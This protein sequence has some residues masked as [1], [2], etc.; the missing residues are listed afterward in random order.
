MWFAALGD[1]RQSPWFVSFARR[2]LEGSP[3]VLRLLAA[4]PFGGRPPRYLRAELFDYRFTDV[5]TRRRTGAWWSRRELGT[6]LPAVSLDD[7][8]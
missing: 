5:A 2:L 6:Y 1:V 3:D 8:R 7:F 4:D